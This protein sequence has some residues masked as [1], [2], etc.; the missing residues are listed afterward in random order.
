[1][2][3]ESI[4]CGLGMRERRLDRVL[5]A[6]GAS[7]FA[8][9]AVLDRVLCAGADVGAGEGMGRL[10]RFVRF[11]GCIFVRTTGGAGIVGH[12]STLGR[13]VGGGVVATL[14][15][16]VGVLFSLACWTTLG[17]SSRSLRSSVICCEGAVMPLRDEAQSAM[18]CM[19]LS[20]GVTVGFVMCLCWNT[21]VSLSLS[22]RVDLMWHL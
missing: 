18:A 16:A 7:S 11:G 14:G 17:A 2:R 5:R 12:V 15:T 6:G 13:P 10:R 20:A 21:T 4:T 19:S 9:A 8:C 3:L 22:L 1:M